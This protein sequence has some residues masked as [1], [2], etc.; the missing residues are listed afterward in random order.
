MLTPFILRYS[1]A[2]AR[3]CTP[4]LCAFPHPVPTSPLRCVCQTHALKPNLPQ[5]SRPENSGLHSESAVSPVSPPPPRHPSLSPHNHVS[6]SPRLPD[7]LKIIARFAHS[8]ARPPSHK[9]WTL[10]LTAR[11]PQP[12]C[13]LC[14]PHHTPRH[15]SIHIIHIPYNAQRTISP[16]GPDCPAPGHHLCC[17]RTPAHT[18]P[19]APPSAPQNT[20]S[21]PGTLLS[22]PSRTPARQHLPHAPFKSPA[23]PAHRSQ[24]KPC[25]S[26]L[27]V[28]ESRARGHHPVPCKRHSP[29]RLNK[30]RPAKPRRVSPPLQPVTPRRRRRRRLRIIY[31]PLLTL[32]RLAA[33]GRHR[34]SR[35]LLR[36]QAPSAAAPDCPGRAE[37][38]EER[39]MQF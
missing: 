11:S 23:Q 25:S 39:G 17:L 22:K 7:R 29:R 14:T 37:R 36:R 27:L 15:A 21:C 2:R 34:H 24:N 8:E 28:V 1:K 32:T 10:K 16:A 4:A 12:Q 26:A 33:C 3:H 31:L 6:A 9:A 19:Q 5:I 13:V 35:A 30:P 38:A 18:C 20:L